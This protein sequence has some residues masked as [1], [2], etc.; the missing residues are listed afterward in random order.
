[1]NKKRKVFV[2][3]MV[4]FSALLSTFSF[5]VYQILKSPNLQVDKEAIS[6]VI[7]RD[8]TFRS[9]QDTLYKY[10]I[11]QDMVSFSFIAK[12]MNYSE[13][14][15]PGLYT[16]Q[17]NMTNLSAVRL[18][19]AGNQIPSK[20]TFSHARLVEELYEPVTRYIEIDSGEFRNALDE[21]IMN[22]T[23]GFNKETIISMFIPN[24]YQVYYTISP[25]NLV[26]KINREYHNFWNEDNKIKAAK[27]GLSQLEVSTLASI[28]QAEARKGDESKIIAGLYMNR[29]KQGIPLQADPTLV[30]ATGDFTLKRVLNEHKEVDSP[31]NTYKH[32]GLPPGPINMPT[33]HSLRAVLDYA[34][35]DYIF[36]CA[37][38]DFS[39]FHNFTASLREHN[40]NARKY[41]RQLSIEQRKARQ[42]K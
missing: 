14:V 42:A 20:L 4:V 15:K 10:D 41:Q 33:I 22:N 13:A 24:T 16:I 39:G 23:E 11:V 18:L 17:A 29:L 19:R 28:V 1:M 8:A 27:I 2:I 40:E 6:F 35:H 36:M 25:E 34:R 30:F 38:E 32:K 3:I 12:L 7:P 37:K 26:L 21:Y 31:Y 5:Y 9:V